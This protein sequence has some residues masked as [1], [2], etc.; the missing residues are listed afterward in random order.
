MVECAK[1]EKEILKLKDKVYTMKK[2]T[3][4]TLS[5][6]IQEIKN[7]F[8]ERSVIRYSELNG[9]DKEQYDAFMHMEKENM[10]ETYFE[11]YKVFIK[12]VS[13]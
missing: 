5:S 2:T 6:K 12:R 8:G 4:T 11:G 10:V 7:I 1:L 9:K 13:F 3:R